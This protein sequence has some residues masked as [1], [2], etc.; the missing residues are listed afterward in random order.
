MTTEPVDT[1][2]KGKK[3][4]GIPYNIIATSRCVPQLNH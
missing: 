3:A 1:A 2:S 4:T